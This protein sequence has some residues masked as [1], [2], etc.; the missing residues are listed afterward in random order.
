MNKLGIY[1]HVPFCLRKCS[2][3]DFYSVT[4]QELQTAYV[5]ALLTQLQTEQEKCREYLVDTVYLGGGT[6]SLL[7]GKQVE[8]IFD[9]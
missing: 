2:Y 5:D 4:A 1:I 8:R 9:R 7:S 3:C 6:P